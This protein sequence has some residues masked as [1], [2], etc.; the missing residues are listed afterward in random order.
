MMGTGG[1]KWYS[2]NL[3]IDRSQIDLYNLKIQNLDPPNYGKQSAEHDKMDE[4]MER[5]AV[6]MIHWNPYTS[7]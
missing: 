3:L 1:I 2:M 4:V 7:F 6:D 5:A